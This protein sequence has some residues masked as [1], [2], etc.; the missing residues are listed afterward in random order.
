VCVLCLSLIVHAQAGD[1]ALAGVPNVAHEVASLVMP[2]AKQSIRDLIYF[3]VVQLKA[4]LR[5]LPEPLM[6]LALYDKWLVTSEVPADE[7]L[8]KVARA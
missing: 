4:Y 6:T 3:V 7:R 5:E 8:A 1:I 2:C